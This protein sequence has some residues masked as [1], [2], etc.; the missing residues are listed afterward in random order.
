MLELAWRG[1][2]PVTLAGGERR[3]FLLDGDE[4]TLTG[5]A[6]GEG[7]RVGFGEVSGIVLP[8]LSAR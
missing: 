4:L 8:A 6:Q 1:T 5:Y 3:T 2:E 7:Y